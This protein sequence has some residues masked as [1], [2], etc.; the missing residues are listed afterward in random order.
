MPQNVKLTKEDR[1]KMDK[2][3]GAAK[4]TDF[5]KEAAYSAFTAFIEGEGYLDIGSI[6]DQVFEELVWTYFFT[7][8]VKVKVGITLC[9]NHRT[10]LNK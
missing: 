10:S 6:A 9:K 2:G 7:L 1:D 3:G 4:R 8:R 5:D